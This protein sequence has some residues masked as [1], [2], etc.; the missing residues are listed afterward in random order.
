MAIKGSVKDAGLADVC[1]L[2]A[3]GL[4]T[5]CLSVT[6]GSKFGQIFFDRGRITFATIVNRRDRL[7]DRL[8]Q[9]GAITQ[10][11]LDQAIEEQGRGSDRRLGEIL[12]DQ[13][14]IDHDT[15][16]AH[17]HQQI[18]DAIYHL[19]SW[20]RGHFQFEPGK[21]P[22][23]G[24]I[25][26]SVNPE[27]L[28]LEGARRVD[29]WSVIQKKIPSLDLVFALDPA[30]L[31]AAAMELTRNQQVL[32]PLVDGRRSVRQ[33]AADAGLDEYEA[34]RALYGLVQAGLATR[35]GRRDPGADSAPVETQ[36][37]R[38]LGIAFY[39]TAMLDEA[40]REFQRVVEADA[41]DATALRY[42]ALVALR[43]GDTAVAIQ[44][45]TELLQR[46]PRRIGARLNL[47]FAL[48]L[49]RRYD[50][51]LAEL[52]E[53][54]LLAPEDPRI[55]LAEGATR[56]LAGDAGAGLDR[57]RDYRRLLGGEAEPPATYFYFAALAEAV[58]G[59]VDQ[60]RTLVE[61][62]L[63]AH[64]SNASLLLLGGNLA[65]RDAD[66]ETAEAAYQAAAEEDPSIPQLFRNLGDMARR[67]GALEEALEHYRRATEL[68]PDLGDEVYTHMADL[69]YR[70]NER[71]EAVRCWRR[72]VELNPRSEVARNRLEVVAGADG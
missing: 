48:R 7:G 17:I 42:L 11:Q 14:V 45:L 72:A 8:L 10:A 34:A 69:Y 56:L 66:M 18:Q 27:S 38:N 37:A 29:E 44:R 25:L 49:E 30:R 23:K 59:A 35:I 12:V 58:T 64:P 26:I 22:E 40:E 50:E 39:E 68:D 53:A 31:E 65:E 47:A 67:R 21:T 43:K 70:R 55:A 9:Q 41:N 63:D 51:A 36:D 54:R 61:E 52:V 2:L 3:L 20:R 4:K 32:A 46:G 6:D 16:T 28:L 71:D 5:G 13:G 57:F 33:L 1:H 60:A 19:F 24:E 15:L 62:G